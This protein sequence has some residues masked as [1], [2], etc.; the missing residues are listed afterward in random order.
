MRH[1]HQ[2]CHQVQETVC[3]DPGGLECYAFE[4]GFSELFT[5]Q[6]GEVMPF[7]DEL[8]GSINT[9]ICDLQPQQVRSY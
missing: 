2:D 8:L 4:W 7:I 6:V 3:P 5:V 1:L 9:T